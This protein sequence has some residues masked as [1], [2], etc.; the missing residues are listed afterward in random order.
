MKVRGWGNFSIENGFASYGTTIKVNMII[1]QSHIAL[2]E[3]FHKRPN[4]TSLSR[5]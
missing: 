3:R 2:V 5:P 1:T 4:R